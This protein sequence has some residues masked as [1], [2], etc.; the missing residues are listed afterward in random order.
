MPDEED[1][2]DFDLHRIG[3]QWFQAHAQQRMQIVGFWFV[4]MSFLTTGAVLAYVNAKLVP[5]LLV[6]ICIA[7]ASLLFLFLDLRTR[8]LIGYG[9]RLM[10]AVEARLA[11][12]HGVPEIKIVAEM[13][14][15]KRK[16]VSYRLL[17]SALYGGTALISLSTS[18]LTVVVA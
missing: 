5:S 18:V 2:K 12:E 8:E 3:W 9:E 15:K 6:Q 1:S 10:A 14:T 13:H 11:G 7:L 17:F 4:A 16:T